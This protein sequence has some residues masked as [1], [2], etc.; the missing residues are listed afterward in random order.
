MYKLLYCTSRKNMGK[1][2]STHP[3]PLDTQK[4]LFTTTTKKGGKER[5]HGK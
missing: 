4:E 1:N 3:N 5:M 2:T